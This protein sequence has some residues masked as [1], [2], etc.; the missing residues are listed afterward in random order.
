MTKTKPHSKS[1]DWKI[2]PK[3]ENLR[4]KSSTLGSMNFSIR[5]HQIPDKTS[6]EKFDER[7]TKC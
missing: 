5:K 4:F 7:F 6:Y 1:R 2:R 3:N